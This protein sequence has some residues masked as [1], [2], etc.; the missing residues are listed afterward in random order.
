[1]QQWSVLEDGA[2]AHR[3]QS[4]EIETFYHGNRE[5]NALIRQD[6]PRARSEQEREFLEAQELKRAQEQA[7]RDVAERDARLAAQMQEELFLA[8]RMEQREREKEEEHRIR[9]ILRREEGLLRPSSQQPP[10]S[11]S[12]KLSPRATDVAAAT[13]IPEP[14]YANTPTSEER[15]HRD[16][17]YANTGS[18]ASRPILPKL[19]HAVS[20]AHYAG[21]S[22][23]EIIKRIHEQGGPLPPNSSGSSSFS[24]TGFLSSG[25]RQPLGV[26][27]SD[28]FTTSRGASAV[29]DPPRMTSSPLER[30]P[31]S[32]S[33]DR[34]PPGLSVAQFPMGGVS[35]PT[36]ATRTTRGGAAVNGRSR[37]V[38]RENGSLQST[39]YLNH[40][41]TP[42]D[43]KQNVEAAVRALSLSHSDEEDSDDYDDED[44]L[45]KV[46]REAVA[47]LTGG[48][49]AAGARALASNSGSAWSQQ[50]ALRRHS[51]EDEDEILHW[52]E[53]E[54]RERIR[55]EEED[56]RLA[57]RLQ[58]EEEAAA[59]A[60]EGGAVGGVAPERRQMEERDRRLAEK[61]QRHEEEKLRRAKERA[62]A[63]KLA[64]KE[65]NEQERQRLSS[66]QGLPSS[67]SPVSPHSRQSSADDTAEASGVPGQRRDIS[68]QLVSPPQSPASPH[69]TPDDE[70]QPLYMN[71]PSPK[72]Y[73]VEQTALER[74]L[75]PDLLMTSTNGGSGTTGA[76]ATIIAG[77]TQNTYGTERSTGMIPSDAAVHPTT[78]VSSA[79]YMPFQGIKRPGV[80]D[81]KKNRHS[82][83]ACK[84]Q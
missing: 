20:E 69:G 29:D 65:R 15:M 25:S 47:A 49:M 61:L 23:E 34:S 38:D 4:E 73:T 28:S 41:P 24:A 74:D 59:R 42:E 37:V 77:T 7:L 71:L 11:P 60:Q 12:S 35:R 51:V 50:E 81:K 1:R 84:T 6:R 26:S 80:N 33:S 78:C 53:A 30:S 82:K 67:S 14:L 32:I 27:V 83:E 17:V 56:E 18:N 75:A 9:D 62:R 64:K 68:G 31:N 45:E 22:A 66:P 44:H 43:Q 16:P 2:L 72:K 63:K 8:S 13:L 70:D 19:T 54:D 5:R 76:T 21:R 3:L 46:T 57:R 58:E 79:P 55:Q 36:P 40:S 52:S 39:E 10:L 48:A